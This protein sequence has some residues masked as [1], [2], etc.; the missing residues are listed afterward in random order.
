MI[1]KTVASGQGH[2]SVVKLLLDKVAN[3]EA[4]DKSGWTPPFMVLE[5]NQSDYSQPVNGDCD[6]LIRARPPSRG[7]ML[8]LAAPHTREN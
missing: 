2:E 7:A 6:F 3:V 1:G 4:A 8:G 5:A